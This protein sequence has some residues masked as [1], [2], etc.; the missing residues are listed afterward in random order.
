MAHCPEPERLAAY[1]DGRLFPEQRERLEEHLA[2][3]DGCA[4][5]IAEAMRFDALTSPAPARAHRDRWVAAAALAVVAPTAAW[6]AL[7][8]ERPP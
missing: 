5:A 1:L 7:G 2:A 8:S 3:C 6:L 4:N